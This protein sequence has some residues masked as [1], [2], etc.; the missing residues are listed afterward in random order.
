M[1]KDEPSRSMDQTLSDLAYR[2]FNYTI[3]SPQSPLL[4]V[5][6]SCTP[7]GDGRSALDENCH[8][9]ERSDVVIWWYFLLGA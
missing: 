5:I 3:L 6:A 1:E 8:H 7:A 9:E 2:S 4:C